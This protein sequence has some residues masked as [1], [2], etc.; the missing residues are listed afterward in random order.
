MTHTK[1]LKCEGLAKEETRLDALVF[2]LSFDFKTL[3][4]KLMLLVWILSWD[5]SLLQY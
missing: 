1:E 3:H 2:G 5:V 4:L